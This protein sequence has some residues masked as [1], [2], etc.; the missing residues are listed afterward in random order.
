MRAAE[1]AFRSGGLLL[2]S[3]TPCPA[4]CTGRC[5]TGSARS[6]SGAPRP[7]RPTSPGA[8][9][10][11]RAERTPWRCPGSARSRVRSARP[12]RPDGRGTSR[13]GRAARAP[14]A[15]SGPSRW[16][17]SAR[18]RRSPRS[19]AGSSSAR[20]SRCAA[21]ESAATPKVRAKVARARSGCRTCTYVCPRTYPSSVLSAAHTR[22][23]SRNGS[24]LGEVPDDE[25]RQPEDLHR[26]A[27]LDRSLRQLAENGRQ[28][29]DRVHV[30]VG[31][32]VGDAEQMR[33]V[34]QVPA[35][36]RLSACRLRAR[37][38]P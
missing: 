24:G 12:L 10:R 18:P 20:R 3:C 26:F 21:A 25:M 4:G 2:S 29:L 28:L 35:R 13:A 34:R 15:A 7:P 37:A 32:I 23:A 16:R 6:I 8:R 33:D 36:R 1:H 38:C 9:A 5:R 14:A 11:R 30:I 31:V 27:A 22:V 17:A 19:P